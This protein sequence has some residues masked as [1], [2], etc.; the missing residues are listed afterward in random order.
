VIAIFLL[1]LNL[2]ML[3]LLMF[4]PVVLDMLLGSVALAIGVGLSLVVKPWRWLEQ[5]R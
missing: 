2:A 1:V 5:R 3:S 4:P